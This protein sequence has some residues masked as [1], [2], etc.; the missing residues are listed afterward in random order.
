VLL[1][2]R[3]LDV[4]RADGRLVLVRVVEALDV[5][6]VADVERCDVVGGCQGQV[7]EAAV[8]GDVGAGDEC[9]SG[10]W[11]RG[12]V[13]GGVLLD[14]DGVTG[15]GAEVIQELSDTGLAVGVLALGVDDPDLTQ[16]NSRSKSS[17]LRVAGNVL[18]V[19][20][21]AALQSC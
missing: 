21:T 15:L 17:A 12:S 5:V 18:D 2:R 19:L 7:D 3:D 20:D 13:L 6:Q 11:S 10:L 16:V 4:V 1:V 9:V 14:G 8:L